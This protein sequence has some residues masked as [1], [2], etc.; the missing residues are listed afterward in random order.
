MLSSSYLYCDTATKPAQVQEVVSYLDR[1]EFG[2]EGGTGGPS[3][4]AVEY[5][6]LVDSS[7]TAGAVA[8]VYQKLLDEQ[9]LVL[10]KGN[11]GEITSFYA[12]LS[13]FFNRPQVSKMVERLTSNKTEKKKERLA[14]L[15]NLYNLYTDLSNRYS[16][17]IAILEYSL[18]SEQTSAVENLFETIDT[19][20][21]ELNTTNAQKRRVYQL[22]LKHI[23]DWGSDSLYEFL[24]K[25][26]SAY[27]P[28]EKIPEEV[29]KEVS[30][31]VVI[32]L[33][34][35][36]V[37]RTDRLFESYVLQK[38][39]QTNIFKLLEIFTCKNYE[40]YINFCKSHAGYVESLGLKHEDLVTK[41]RLL[42]LISL[43]SEEHLLPY[44]LVSK[45]LEIDESE[46]ELFV[47]ET[48]N[49]TGMLDA[50]MDQ[51]NKNIIV[52]HAESRIFHKND[53]E[54]LHTKL[55][56]WKQNMNQL[57]NVINTAK[58]EGIVS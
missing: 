15:G 58:G 5:K 30:S 27:D 8:E 11:K 52:R 12:I 18:E 17:L 38:M 33:K 53:W 46:V 47:I 55:V 54:V 6:K 7:K 24:V 28:S 56:K 48:I 50:R 3:K 34:D 51:L 13:T 16:I 29:E 31:N 23:A 40:D 19:R 36:E 45:V 32:F 2:S 42:T 37:M 22:I 20:L 49:V 21:K 9:D 44:S 1:L 25:Y 14:T 35:P 57:L 4:R 39:S 10:K 26:Y 41:I 43:A